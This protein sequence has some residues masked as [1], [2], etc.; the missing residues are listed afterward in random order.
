MATTRYLHRKMRVLIAVAGALYI[1]LYG[2]LA[3]MK[4]AL[5]SFRFYTALLVSFIVALLILELIQFMWV[6]LDDYYQ[7][8]RLKYIR[9]AIQVISGIT[10]SLIVDFL[11]FAVYFGL[12]GENI[13]TIG[14]LSDDFIYVFY[15]L[16]GLNLCYLLLSF[17]RNPVENSAAKIEPP[18]LA[19]LTGQHMPEA[20]INQLL[21]IDHKGLHI[22]LEHRDILYCYRFSRKSKIVTNGKGNYTSNA[23]ISNIAE[24]LHASGF[25]QTNRGFIIN[26]A[27]IKGYI[28]G[29]KRDTLQLVI[30][31]DFKIFFAGLATDQLFVTKEYKEAFKRAFDILQEET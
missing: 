15:L 25:L 30:K 8:N 4:T 6:K 12:F 3:E 22:H 9:A 19:Q 28:K 7:G 23:A 13:L 24:Q 26:L 14:F 1:V 29:I 18:N 11:C 27:T 21:V 2:R 5:V 31:R 16:A 17:T 20:S 10:L